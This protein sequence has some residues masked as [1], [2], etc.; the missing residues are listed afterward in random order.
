MAA[1]AARHGARKGSRGVTSIL[2]AFGVAGGGLLAVSVMTMLAGGPAAPDLDPSEVSTSTSRSTGL[3]AGFRS[4][5]AP[6]PGVG[7][8]SPGSARVTPAP[9]S[10]PPRKQPAPAVPGAHGAGGPSSAPTSAPTPTHSPHGRTV[11]IPASAHPA[12]PTPR[13]APSATPT[14]PTPVDSGAPLPP[15][16]AGADAPPPG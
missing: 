15:D 10:V 14:V 8:A 3:P 6:P 16:G 13:P 2:Q 12:T 5:E 4:T 11:P 1:G 9:G 7:G